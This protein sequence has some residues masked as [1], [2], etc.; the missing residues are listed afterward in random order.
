MNKIF[1]NNLLIKVHENGVGGSKIIGSPLVIADSEQ[2]RNRT[3]ATRLAHHCA[4][5]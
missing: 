5:H 3:W 4:N 2:A 1:K